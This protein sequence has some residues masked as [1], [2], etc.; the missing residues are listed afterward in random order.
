M[1]SIETLIK[2]KYDSIL[3]SLVMLIA[4]IFFTLFQSYMNKDLDT[5]DES[6]PTKTVHDKLVI[7]SVTS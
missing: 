7:S 6:I 2:Y 4:L 1:N 5:I 3:L